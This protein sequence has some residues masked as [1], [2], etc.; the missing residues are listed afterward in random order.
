MQKTR[1]S[2]ELLGQLHQAVTEDLLRRISSGEA[3]PAE[4]NAAI[5]LLQNNGIEAVAAEESPLG[6]LVAAL[7]T[8]DDE[9]SEY[10]YQ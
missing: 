6:K 2:E 3:T 4:L 9:D 5:K 8:F 10:K 7:P 1:A